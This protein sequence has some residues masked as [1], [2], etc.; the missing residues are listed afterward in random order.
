ML[1]PA[2]IQ[3]ITD[4]VRWPTAHLSSLRAVSVGSTIALQ[5][6][7][8]RLVRRGV[9]VLQVYGSTET[10]PIAIYTRLG[11]EVSREDSTGL[12]GLCCEAI[13]MDKCGNELPA[14]VPGEIAVRGPNVL[15]EYWGDQ[16][17]T[18]DALRA[19]WYRTG[20]IAAQ[21]TDGHFWI[22]DRKNRL[23][24]SGGENIY[25][26]EVERVL[27][28]HPDVAE[29]AVIG[30]PH[31]QWDEVPIAYV[32]MQAG[33]RTDAKTLV[34]HVQ[35]HLARFKVPREI[36]FTKELPR[37]ALGKIQHSVLR[38]LDSRSSEGRDAD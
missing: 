32:I 12:P 4:S 38:E 5:Y 30:R 14:G 9:P 19:G 1:V 34:A 15:Q 16:Q 24:I 10:S 21:D 36:I 35:F 3:A 2:I 13:V 20:D 33:T 26:A 28:N 8:D 37:T 23:I 22:K 17:A 18:R 7:I 25:P 29:C 6:L 31:P 11:G 27:L